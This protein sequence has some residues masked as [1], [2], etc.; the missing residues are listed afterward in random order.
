MERQKEKVII[1]GI[2]CANCAA[3]VE[4]G[5]QALDGVAEANLDF[6]GEKLFVT[7]QEGSAR[8]EVY[9][10]IVGRVKEIETGVTPAP[11]RDGKKAERP[12]NGP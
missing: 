1:K 4:R 11:D 3:K 9:P 2:D 7:Y 10:R 12:P 5:I 6:A 8:T